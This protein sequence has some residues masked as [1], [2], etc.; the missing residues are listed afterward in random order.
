MCGIFG[1]VKLRGFFPAEEYA[2]FVAL[3]DKVA[4]RGPD[5]SGYLTFAVKDDPAEGSGAF[6]VFFGHRRLS[7]IDLSPAGHQPMRDGED[8]CLIYNGEIFNYIELREDLKRKGH[9]FSTQTDTEVILKLYREYGEEGFGMLNGMWAMALL[10]IPQKK[11]VLSRDRFS[12]KPLYYTQ[13]QDAFYFSSEIK[14]LLP[15]LPEK[16]MNQDTFFTF[17]R[18]GI[19]DHNEETFF[20]GI[21]RMKPMHNR[22][23]RLATGAV[24]E[25]KYWDYSVPAGRIPEKDAL[26]QFRELFVDSVRIRLRSDVPVGAL[27]SGGLDSS[28]ISYI[29]HRFHEQD[30]STFSVISKFRQYSEEKY[31]DLVCRGLNIPNRKIPFEVED[32]TTFREDIRT[33]LNYHDEPFG[34]FSVIAQF[35]N[36]EALRKKKEKPSS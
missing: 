35:R 22:V 16:K 2:R 28:S 26:F 3:A 7:I 10:D 15:L 13:A 8:L 11:L 1:A 12:M 31:I 36:F 21:R 4:Y 14:Q 17:I 18:Q 5:D 25:K 20:S 30:F 9:T 24:E 23:L 27:L 33:A 6:D 32:E 29:A 19:S 34:V